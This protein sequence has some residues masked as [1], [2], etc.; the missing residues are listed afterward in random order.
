MMFER[1]SNSFLRDFNLD[2]LL[3]KF[4]GVIFRSFKKG[5]FIFRE[6]DEVNF[7][8]FILSGEVSVGNFSDDSAVRHLSKCTSG[9]VAGFDDAIS[10]TCYTK[11]AF[12]VTNVNSIEIRKSEFIELTK[13]NDEFNL[14]I[15]KYLSAKIKSLD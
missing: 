8:Y 14:W 5:E 9:D 1:Y 3:C 6:N 7:V 11:S 12:A 4:Q 15:L 13:K 10:G 2:N